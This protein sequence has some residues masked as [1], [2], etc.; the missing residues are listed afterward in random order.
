MFLK[1]LYLPDKILLCW[2]DFFFSFLLKMWSVFFLDKVRPQADYVQREVANTGSLKV[3][4]ESR[5][6]AIEFLSFLSSQYAIASCS[7]LACWQFYQS[8]Y[9]IPAC[10]RG[11]I[12]LSLSWCCLQR[13]W[14]HYNFRF[15]P[16]YYLLC[17]EPFLPMVWI[18]LE[19]W[20]Q[21]LSQESQQHFSALTHLWYIQVTWHI[22]SGKEKH[23]KLSFRTFNITICV[24]AMQ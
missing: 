7:R 1:Y 23:S 13:Q 19:E 12:L 2:R 10:K 16:A 9:Y 3:I 11:G 8:V 21:Q 17:W 22:R 4:P 18:L 5:T 20:L 14:P 24:D 15:I 6:S